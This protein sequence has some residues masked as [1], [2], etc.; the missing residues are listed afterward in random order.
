MGQYDFVL[1]N[2]KKSHLY[3]IQCH[4]C[5]LFGSALPSLQYSLIESTYATLEKVLL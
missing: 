1:E 2:F 3:D 5:S 4:Y